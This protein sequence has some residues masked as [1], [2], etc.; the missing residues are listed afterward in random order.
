VHEAALTVEAVRVVVE[1]FLAPYFSCRL[2]V[3]TTPPLS[4][5]ACIDGEYYADD[6]S[7]CI[8]KKSEIQIVISSI[9]IHRP[10]YQQTSASICCGIVSSIH[11]VGH[12]AAACPKAGTPTWS[13]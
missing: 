10:S 12:Q 4:I 2:Y 13:V 6:F 8:Q 1:F 9:C 5:T 11:L 7:A 3:V